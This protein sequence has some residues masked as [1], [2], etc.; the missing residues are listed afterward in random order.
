MDISETLVA[1]SDQLNAV[2]L[3]TGPRTV[4]VDHVDVKKSDQQPVAIHLVEFP[5][6]PFKP[7]ATVRRQ[8]A[9]AWGPQSDTYVGRRLTLFNDPT[10]KWAGQEIG[11]IRVSHASHIDK[12]NKLTLQI[13]R[14]VHKT[15]VIEPLP[16]VPSSATLPPI[17]DDDALDFARAISE[18]ATVAE[19]NKISA[20]LKT[21]DLGTHRTQLQTAWTGRNNELKGTV[22]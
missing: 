7:C 22:A 15:L 13:A 6:R 4:T 12:P 18:A 10:V 11:G 17:T 21:R 9:N 19:L 1:K 2:D 3:L 5:G 14:G 20:E 16:D 8:I